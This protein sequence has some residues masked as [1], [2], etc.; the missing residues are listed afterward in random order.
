[1]FCPC[2]GIKLRT[3]PRNKNGRSILD[4]VKRVV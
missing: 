1:V 3:K 4:P 2:C